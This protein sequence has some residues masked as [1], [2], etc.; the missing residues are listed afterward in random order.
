MVVFNILQVQSLIKCS[1]YVGYFIFTMLNLYLWNFFDARVKRSEKGFYIKLLNL[2]ILQWFSFLSI[3]SNLNIRLNEEGA[4]LLNWNVFIYYVRKW[5]R[6]WNFKNALCIFENL[7]LED[8]YYHYISSKCFCHIWK[9]FKRYRRA[10]ILFCRGVFC[11]FLFFW[12][13][14][15]KEENLNGLDSFNKSDKN[16]NM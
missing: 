3:L 5:L 13:G 6:N 12:K 9:K 1:L 7:F 2:L 4:S 8:V 16:I 14:N 10:L 11:L 15:R